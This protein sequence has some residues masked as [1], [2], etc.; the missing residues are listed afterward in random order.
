MTPTEVA[1]VD[2]RRGHGDPIPASRE[3]RQFGNH[4]D[5][6]SPPARELAERID[7]YKVLHHRR[8]ITYEEL[9]HVIT[10]LGYR[11]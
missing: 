9:H 2:R 11:K 10:A 1:F 8:F 5:E 4:Y 6:L 7:E 3:R